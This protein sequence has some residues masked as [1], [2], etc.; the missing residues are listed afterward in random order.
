M[1]RKQ[2]KGKKKPRASPTG[3]GKAKQVVHDIAR[4]YN[5]ANSDMEPSGG[6]NINSRMED[7][8]PPQKDNI[9]NNP[10]ADFGRVVLANARVGDNLSSCADPPSGLVKSSKKSK[11]LVKNSARVV[12]SSSMRTNNNEVVVAEKSTQRQPKLSHKVSVYKD[13]ELKAALEVI[14]TVMELDAALPFNIPVDGSEVPDYYDIIDTPMDFGTILHNLETGVK[15]MNAKDV[16]CDAEH[17]W[18]NCFKY[19]KTGSFI[20]EL[21][22]RVMNKFLKLWAEAGLDKE[23]GD[24]INGFPHVSPAI[25]AAS[26]IIHGNR[27][28]EEPPVDNPRHLQH[29]LMEHNEGELR[30]S[31]SHIQ[32]IHSHMNYFQPNRSFCQMPHPQAHPDS[33]PGLARQSHGQSYPL[34]PVVD[35]STCFQRNQIRGESQ[36]HYHPLPSSSKAPYQTHQDYMYPDQPHSSLPYTEIAA[37]NGDPM[38]RYNKYVP[39]SPWGPMTNCH[40]FDHA[41]LHQRQPHQASATHIHHQQPEHCSY[42]S[43]A[44]FS[45]PQPYQLPTDTGRDRNG[46]FALAPTA[47]SMKRNPKRKPSL[48]EVP[49][50]NNNAQ[51]EDQIRSSRPSAIIDF[52]LAPPAESMKRTPKHKKARL[53]ASLVTNNHPQQEDQVQSCRPSAVIGNASPSPTMITSGARTTRQESRHQPDQVDDNQN[54]MPLVNFSETSHQLTVDN[55]QPQSSIPSPG[56]DEVAEVTENDKGNSNGPTNC[57]DLWSSTTKITISFD[58]FGQPIGDETPKLITF[59]GTLARNG[60]LAPLTYVDWRTVPEDNKAKMWKLVQSK[61]D[62]DPQFRDWTTKSVGKKWKD[63]KA[64]LK[65]TH[66]LSHD[67]DEDR[68]AACDDRVFPEQWKFLVSFWNSDLSKERSIKAK[69]SRSKQRIHHTTGRKSF[70]RIRE[71]QRAKMPDREPPS[72]ADLF[73]FTRTRKDGQPVNEESSKLISALQAAQQQGGASNDGGI[74]DDIFSS[75]VKIN[76][77]NMFGPV[78][79]T[80]QM[81]VASML[82][83]E[84]EAIQFVSEAKKE[85]LEMKQKMVS[86]EQSYTQMTDQMTKLVSMMSDIHNKKALV[87]PDEPV[88]NVIVL[89]SSPVPALAHVEPAPT[90]VE[91]VVDVTTNN[92]DNSDNSDKSSKEV[93]ELS[94]QRTIRKRGIAQRTSTRKK[95]PRKK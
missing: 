10:L 42:Q 62:I 92:S 63:W 6:A 93:F 47:E 72:K 20:M 8:A 87:E 45:Q 71:E 41:A 7:E 32:S 24:D 5:G 22:K 80:P 95:I 13:Q 66:Y 91:Q 3:T 51:Q 79:Q 70:A 56:P 86:M 35:C 78:Q 39:Q 40:Q 73:I 33:V 61:F 4:F 37:A 89:P 44:N 1:K 21:G 55:T 18:N 90:H 85:V 77:S 19:N 12:P 94:S 11:S 49:V 68:L 82:S 64:H 15:Y 57:L 9:V 59:L 83:K 28:P 76:R 52:S 84:N 60:E 43:H 65:S 31:M 54:S 16:L 23:S 36:Q 46:D 17:I 88:P 26:F 27:I 67:N 25:P 34:H 30:Q 75:V 74:A 50:T 14:R 48:P 53:P 81:H 69:A 2:G 58:E 38:T 29:N